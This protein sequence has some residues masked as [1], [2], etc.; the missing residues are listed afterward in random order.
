M[1]G[2]RDGGVVHRIQVA[3]PAGVVYAVLA[4]APKLPLYF[5][6]SIHVERLDTDGVDGGRERLRMW[7]WVGGRLESWTSWR[8]L[9]PVE[10]RIEVRPEAPGSRW[11]RCA[12]WSA[13]ATA[14]RT[15][16][17][18]NCATATATTPTTAPVPGRACGGRGGSPTGGRGRSPT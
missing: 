9:D 11:S 14:A 15:P 1:A 7:F 13:S 8:H 16:A 5:A 10:R 18:W 17:N 2:E 6:P 3:A 4:D 12:A